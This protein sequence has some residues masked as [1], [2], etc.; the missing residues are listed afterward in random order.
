MD[1]RDLKFTTSGVVDFTEYKVEKVDWNASVKNKANQLMQKFSNK[2]TVLNCID[3]II[4]AL[5][6]TDDC[7]V[8]IIEIPEFSCAS[9]FYEDV[10]EEIEKL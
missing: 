1:E 8:N 5:E 9:A 10:R 6:H 7:I 3:E 2:E 4:I